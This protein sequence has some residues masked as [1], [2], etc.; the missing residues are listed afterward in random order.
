MHLKNIACL[1]KWILHKE[2]NNNKERFTLSGLKVKPSHVNL[3]GGCLFVPEDEANEFHA[4]QLRYALIEKR[5]IN[6]TEQPLF[7]DD[8]C[9]YS[10][11]IIDID[12]RCATEVDTWHMQNVKD[13]VIDWCQVM[14]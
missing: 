3:G 5:E 4:K 13:A 6:L 10:P 8:G 2:G 12:L 1:Q 9:V 11:V 14:F 7:C